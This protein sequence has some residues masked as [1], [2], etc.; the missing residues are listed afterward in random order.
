MGEIMLEAIERINQT[1]KFK[2]SGFIP[3]VIY[4]DSVD[5]ATSVKFEEQALK[6]VLSRYGSYAK[7]WI[8]YN[9]NKKFGFIK[10]VQRHPVSGDVMHIDVQVASIDREMRLQIPIVF[11]GEEDLTYRNLLLQVDKFETTVFGKMA[12]MPDAIYV[13]VS[14]MN[15]GDTITLDN[16]DLDKQ[17]DIVESEDEVYG[18]IIN[19]KSIAEDEADEAE[20]KSEAGPEAA[21]ETESE[22]E[23]KTESETKTE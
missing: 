9:D 5:G 3:G 22:T 12:L 4:G 1:R 21:P 16:F 11:K 8:K 7:G 13:D 18:R 2:E 10:E 19:L 23:E 20:T 14:E 17:L 6:R 15:F